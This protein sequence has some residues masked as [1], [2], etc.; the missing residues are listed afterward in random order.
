MDHWCGPTSPYCL[1]F[2]ILLKWS[3]SASF[4]ARKSVLKDMGIYRFPVPSPWVLSRLEPG[5]LPSTH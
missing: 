3:S 1:P 2:K 5:P 4:R